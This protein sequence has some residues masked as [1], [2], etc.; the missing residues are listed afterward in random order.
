MT[1][2]NNVY[3]VKQ[4]EAGS[5]LQKFFEKLIDNP[6]GL[7]LKDVLK[8]VLGRLEEGEKKRKL[9]NSVRLGVSNCLRIGWL[10]KIEADLLIVTDEGKK[11]YKENLNDPAK[12]KFL[13]RKLYN[14]LLKNKEQQ[15]LE[16]SLPN[17]TDREMLE[18]G[19]NPVNVAFQKAQDRS[20]TA[21][22]KYI[23]GMDPYDFQ[24]MVAAL[25]KAM[26][27]YVSFVAPVGPD[28]GVDVVATEVPLGLTGARIKIQVKH[29]KNKVTLGGL[30]SFAANIFQGESGVF[31]CTGGFTSEAVSY[32]RGTAVCLSLIDKNKLISMWIEYLPKMTVEMSRY[33]PL[34][35]IYFLKLPE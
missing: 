22:E 10:Q 3:E 14:N 25:F 34:E 4:E 35:P 29:Q 6:D 23:D 5:Y 18:A 20:R 32:A 8:I 17:V 28:G 27:Y 30:K 7:P 1:E 2:Q 31:V 11:K 21:I 26:G 9:E 15:V 19:D 33:L 12:F 24:D 16:A 13:S